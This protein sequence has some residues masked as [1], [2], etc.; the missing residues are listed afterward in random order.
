MTPTRAPEGDNEVKDGGE[1]WSVAVHR[2]IAGFVVA[3]VA[4]LPNRRQ[5]IR[6]EVRLVRDEWMST[7]AVSDR[8]LVNTLTE[9]AVHIRS[10]LLLL[11]HEA[12]RIRQRVEVEWFEFQ[13]SIRA[14]KDLQPP[15]N[16][17]DDLL[18]D[19]LNVSRNSWQMLLMGSSDVTPQAVDT[20]WQDFA[21][22]YLLVVQDKV[23]ELVHLTQ[24]QSQDVLD[25][26]ADL[27]RTLSPS[28]SVLLAEVQHV[29][30]E[31]S[32]RI[33]VPSVCSWRCFFDDLTD[34]V[35]KALPQ[36][37]A[38]LESILNKAHSPLLDDIQAIANE[39]IHTALKCI[40]DIDRSSRPAPGADLAARRALTRALFM[41]E[42]IEQAHRVDQRVC[43]VQA[44]LGDA[45]YS[46]AAVLERL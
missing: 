18:A 20:T 4:S 22:V 1:E 3:L 38:Y 37:S 43:A 28:P 39:C 17:D 41:P 30:S 40:G 13:A 44:D 9:I 5:V 45:K 11:D 15:H 36:M 10:S 33:V 29:I 19:I 2:D 6:D 32:A 24:Q 25:D 34:H 31:V 21:H 14:R 27:V 35:V 16:V 23:E 8:V 7:F 12:T 42:P 26:L 46:L